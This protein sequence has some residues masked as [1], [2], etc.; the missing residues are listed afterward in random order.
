[1]SALPSVTSIC[2]GEVR[3]LGEGILH[4]E[5]GALFAGSSVAAL[6]RLGRAALELGGDVV[7]ET[8]DRGDFVEVDVGDFLEAGEAFGDQQLR[9]RFVDV[10]LV[11]EQRGTLDELALALL[12][13]V[14]LGED[15]D[16]RDGELRSR[17]ARSGR[18]G[19]SRG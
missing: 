5:R 7:V 17:G 12:A 13:G 3:D 1:M 4:T 16:L 15:V 8:F 6:E 9:Q 14:G 19:R 2:F 10:E 11:L 18:G